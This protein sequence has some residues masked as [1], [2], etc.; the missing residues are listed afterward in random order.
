MTDRPP[1]G[2]WIGPAILFCAIVWALIFAA[3]FWSMT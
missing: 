1:P 2:Y 3:I